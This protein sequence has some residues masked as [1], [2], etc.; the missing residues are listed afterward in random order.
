MR[1]VTSS[2]ASVRRRSEQVRRILEEEGPRPLAARLLRGAAWRLDSSGPQLPVRT[3]DVLAADLGSPP[4]TTALPV[5]PDGKLIVNWVTT[6]PAH[7]SG[8]HT[9]MLRLVRHLEKAGHTCRL[10]LYDVYGSK[11]GDHVATVRAA[12]PD[13]TSEIHDVTDGMQ[14]AHAVFATGWGTAYPVYNDPCAGLRFYLVQDFEPWFSPVGG[15][16]ILAENTY[17]MGFHAFTA[18]C[19][20]ADKLT[21]EFGMAGDWFDFGC[22]TT[23]YRLEGGG[24]RDGVVF[25]ARPD[26]PR[27]AF[28][29]GMMALQLFSR[30]HPEIDIHLYG[31]KVGDFG[32][33]FKDHGLLTPSELNTVYNR[34]FAG[35]SLS[36]TNVSLVPHEMLAT[37]CIPVVNEADHNRVVLDNPY[38]AYAPPTP[39]AL[40][41][42]LHDIV[43][44]PGFGDRSA[45]AAGSVRGRSW[46]D[47]GRAL[48][49][50][51]R[52][53][54]T[55]GT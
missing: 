37:G 1:L 19:F 14:D 21:D 17:H 5:G 23:R 54:L 12:F 18:G 53:E 40:A 42:A 55:A 30:R 13:I 41:D 44:D 7:G 39:H 6:P 50:M 36:M 34:C 4:T 48:E 51:L 45:A 8:G 49:A 46:D 10:Y 31:D 15:A 16:A 28:E 24:P 32:P 52:R 11:A 22:D 38:V 25:Y 2:V 9:T 29:L 43:V 20:L 26:A 47:A 3:A 35:L 33:R 27:R